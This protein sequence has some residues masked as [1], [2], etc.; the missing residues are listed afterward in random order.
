MLYAF[1]RSEAGKGGARNVKAVGW[2][3]YNARVG[4]LMKKIRIVLAD[5]HALVREGIRDLI[6]QERDMEVVAEAAD[7]QEAVQLANTLK[8]DIVLLDIAM[9]GLNGIEATKRIK[10]EQPQT[11]V[12]VLTAYDNEEFILAILEAGASGYLLKNIRSE[13]L[14][15]GIRSVHRGESVLHPSV[16]KTVLERLQTH[17]QREP[18]AHRLSPR[19]LEI[20]EMGARGLVNKEIAYELSLS[21]RTI[22]S[23]WR[24][25][26]TKLGVGSRMEA[27]MLCLKN[28]WIR[29]GGD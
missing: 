21:D 28:E 16:L 29:L 1:R 18:A 15:K 3:C 4:E 13:E 23:H 2:A 24:N 19:E 20:V 22:Q 12:L 26:F 14:L 10:A 6:Q 9:P 7:G 5:D 27:V 11:G 25:I 17:G 8:P